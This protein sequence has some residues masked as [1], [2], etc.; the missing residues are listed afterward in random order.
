MNTIYLLGGILYNITTGSAPPSAGQLDLIQAFNDEI[1]RKE[2]IVR[3]G[4]QVPLYIPY[5]TLL[6]PCAP[7][8]LS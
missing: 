4:V 8:T 6:E 5:L 3:W 1:W 2:E 7:F